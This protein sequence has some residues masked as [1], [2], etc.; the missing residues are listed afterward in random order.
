MKIRIIVLIIAAVFLIAACNSNSGTQAPEVT[1]PPQVEAEQV[2][3]EVPAQEPVEIQA[4][5]P[6]ANEQQEPVDTEPQEAVEPPAEPEPEQEVLP[7]GETTFRLVPEESEAR[8]LIDEVLLGSP[9]TVVGTTSALEGQVAVDLNDPSSAQVNILVDVRTLVTDDGRRNGAIQRWILE[10]GEPG[11]QTAEFNASAISGIPDQVAVGET[12][13]FQITGDF[14]VKGVTKELTFDGS[15][16]LV[17]EDR[18]EGT[19]RTETLYT[20]FTTIPG[21]PPQVASVEE[22]MILEIDFVAVSE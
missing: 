17:S 9:F 8:F 12:F 4:P 18:L 6:T 2:V 21:L 16:A 10:T 14:S 1:S 20:E 3:T 13:D 19:A 7:A 11:N 5:E 22:G 15:A